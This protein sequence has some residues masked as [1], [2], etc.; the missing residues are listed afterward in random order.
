M[1]I[2]D[3]NNVQIYYSGNVLC[4]KTEIIGVQFK[5]ESI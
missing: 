3:L 1:S 2:I 4:F 5:E